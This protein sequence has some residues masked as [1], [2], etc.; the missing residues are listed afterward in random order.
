MPRPQVNEYHKKVHNIKFSEAQ[1]DAAKE[2]GMTLA[3]AANAGF[4]MLVEAQGDSVELRRLESID[5]KMEN[6]DKNSEEAIEELRDIVKKTE[7][8]IASIREAM[9]DLKNVIMQRR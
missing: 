4:S 1:K 2:L 6:V 5:K 7:G 3:Q 8:D 9:R